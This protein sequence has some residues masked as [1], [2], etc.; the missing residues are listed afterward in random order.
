MVVNVIVDHFDQGADIGERTATQS[1]VGDLTKPAFHHIEPGTGCRNEVQM[2][3]WMTFQPGSNAGMFMG[4]IV[5]NDQME[6]QAARDFGINTL[7]KPNEFLMS[8]TGHAI[9]DD[10]AIEHTES[11][12]E[13]GRTVALIVVCLPRWQ[14]RAQG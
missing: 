6:L 9:A 5:V 1:L 10:S 13:R 7:Q 12:K 2:K 11:G 4:S 14:S 8:V 3:A